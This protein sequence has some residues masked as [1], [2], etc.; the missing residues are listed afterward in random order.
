MASPTPERYASSVSALRISCPHA[1]VPSLTQA[2]R[3]NVRSNSTTS[4]VNAPSVRMRPSVAGWLRRAA[5][6]SQAARR[7]EYYVCVTQP[8]D[9][10]GPPGLECGPSDSR[11]VPEEG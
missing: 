10:G 2:L 1:S 11:W 7:A 4:A 5:D 8:V 6:Y 3:I 9:I